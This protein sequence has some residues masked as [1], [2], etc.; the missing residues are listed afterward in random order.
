MGKND[1]EE[2][3]WGEGQESGQIAESCVRCE[4]EKNGGGKC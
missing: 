4:A 1:D 3:G 2:T